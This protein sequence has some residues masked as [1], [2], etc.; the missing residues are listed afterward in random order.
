MELTDNYLWKDIKENPINLTSASKILLKIG[1]K[2][3][4]LEMQR[5]NLYAR[6]LGY[7]C[8]LYPSELTKGQL[9]SMEGVVHIA[10]HARLTMEGVVIG[11]AEQV[12]ERVGIYTPIL[13]LMMPQLIRTDLNGWKMSFHKDIINDFIKGNISDYGVLLIDA[14]KLKERIEML[15]VKCCGRMIE[16][17]NEKLNINSGILNAIFRKRLSY[18]YQQEFRIV[19]KGKLNLDE[20]LSVPIGNISDFSRVLPISIL[21]DGLFFSKT[22]Q[23]I[24]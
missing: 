22:V 24:R 13:S 3:H 9:D 5:G 10:E 6:P 8:G 12:I 18:S 19:F 4:L 16:Y 17:T 14:I 21:R 23:L 2:Q 20:S 15:N 11:D 7:Y 1:K